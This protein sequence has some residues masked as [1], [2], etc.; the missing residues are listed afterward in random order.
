MEHDG[1]GFS[2]VK[3]GAASSGFLPVEEGDVTSGFAPTTVGVGTSDE[4]PLA[5]MNRRQRNRP[6]F[7]RLNAGGRTVE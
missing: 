3:T 7:R 6:N 5:M 4:N 2:I 1:K